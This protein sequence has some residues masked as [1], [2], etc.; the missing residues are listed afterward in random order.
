MTDGVHQGSWTRPRDADAETGR[1]GATWEA[2]AQEMSAE[3]RREAERCGCFPLRA[4]CWLVCTA[5]SHGAEAER[6]ETV[7]RVC[8]RPLSSL[9]FS[10][11]IHPGYIRLQLRPLS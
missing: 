8:K 5:A 10:I 6:P 7:L 1:A 3:S 11:Y 9:P 4:V 2:G